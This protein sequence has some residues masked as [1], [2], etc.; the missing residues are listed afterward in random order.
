MSDGGE[1]KPNKI[2]IVSN[3]EGLLSPVFFVCITPALLFIEKEVTLCLTRKRTRKLTDRS[4][5]S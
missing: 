3:Q 2:I 4:R 1:R 5:N